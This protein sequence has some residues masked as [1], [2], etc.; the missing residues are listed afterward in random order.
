[1]IIVPANRQDYRTIPG[2]R[3]FSCDMI[4]S[5]SL[6]ITIAAAGRSRANRE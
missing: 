3:R 5:E 4:S 6:A 1:M 2:Q